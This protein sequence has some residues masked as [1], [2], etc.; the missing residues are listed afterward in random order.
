MRKSLHYISAACITALFFIFSIEKADAGILTLSQGLRLAAENNRTLK[1]HQKNEL[2]AESE[3][4]I[5]KSAMLPNIN[6]SASHTFLSHAPRAIF[7]N[8][9]VP[10]SEKN[11]SS[12]SIAIQQVLFDFGKN[13][14]LYEASRKILE[15]KRIE[16][17]LIR[18]QILLEFALAYLDL[19]ESEKF[20]NV[21]QKEVESV[22]SHLK[23][24][25]ALFE[26]GVITKNDLLQAEVRLSDAQQRLLKAKNMRS[27]NASRLNN[28]LSFPL[29]REL[30]VA[31]IQESQF[32]YGLLEIKNAWETAIRQRSEIIIVKKIMDS[33]ELEM[34]SKKSELY[35]KLFARL[36]YDYIE[37]KHQLH[38][39]NASMTL[40]MSLNLFSGGS[41]KAEI[42][43]IEYKKIQMYEELQ[44]LA[45]NIRLEIDKNIMDIRNALDRIKV[46]K[47]AIGLAEENLRINKVRYEEGVGTATEVL[48]AI[49]LLTTVET[50]YYS[51]LYDVKRAESSFLHSIGKDLLEVYK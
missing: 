37:N 46:T 35:P 16:T 44:S 15:A 42:S 27:I 26:I 50:N 24:A 29:N 40:G 17:Q 43:K 33:I 14:N 9:S 5:A 10:T 32:D 7:G 28:I 36:S 4:I 38:N 48:D 22:A 34:R 45:D 18:N 49:T 41:T 2:I 11:F 13:K 3:T 20:V 19:L 25:K 12:Y 31:D 21:A 8:T 1:I 51:S 47:D 39:A 6:G 23:N 30:Q